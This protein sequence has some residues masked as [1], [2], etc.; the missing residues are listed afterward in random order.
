VAKANDKAVKANKQFRKSTEETSKAV[1]GFF[2]SLKTRAAVGF[3]A[4]NQGLELA[5]KGF[6]F[7]SA[8]I[9]TPIQAFADFEKALIGVQKTTNLTDIETEALGLEI[10][11]LALRI[12]KT[13]EELLSIA[14]SA[15]QLGVT[16]SENILNF[17]ETIARLGVA[18]DV[19]GEEAATALA[20]ILK[21]TNETVGGVDELASVIVKLGNTFEASESEIL[22]V[23][24]EVAAAAT[25]FGTSSASAVALSAALKSL[26]RRAESSGSAVSRSLIEIDKALR[27]GGQSLKDFERITG[28][29]GEELEK[30]FKEDSLVAFKVFV[31]GLARIEE[32]GGS[33]AE[34]LAKLG[35]TSIRT[36]SILGVLAK[37]SESVE[38]AFKSASKEVIENRALIDESN[39]AFSTLTSQIGLARN[40]IAF[41]ARALGTA[42]APAV[43]SIVKSISEFALEVG[44]LIVSLRKLDLEGVERLFRTVTAA[45]L[46]T[47]AVLN[48]SA[49]VIALQKA[50]IGL[51]LALQSVNKA[52]IILTLKIL[53]VAA[54]VSGVIVGIQLLIENFKNFRLIAV[55]AVSRVLQGISKLRSAINRAFG[56]TKAAEKFAK[57]AEL[58]GK[59][60]EKAGKKIKFSFDAVKKPLEIVTQLLGL[61][62][63][64]TKKVTKETEEL[65]KTSKETSDTAQKAS[66]EELEINKRNLEQLR[67]NAEAEKL[68][69]KAIED[70]KKA[71][72]LLEITLKNV[73][74]TELEIITETRDERIAAIEKA[75]TL[76]NIE[77]DKAADLRI[78][79]EQ[80]FSE[81]S[82]RL[83]DNRI[84]N[85]EDE[86]KKIEDVESAFDS[87]LKV[88]GNIGSEIGNFAVDQFT[89]ILDGIVGFFESGVSKAIGDSRIEAE[90]LV[91]AE[92]ES[93]QNLIEARSEA[94]ELQEKIAKL[95]SVEGLLGLDE[96]GQQRLA[97]LKDELGK[98][99]EIIT[100][101]QANQDKL[102]KQRGAALKEEESEIA[103]LIKVGIDEFK[104]LAKEFPKLAKEFIKEFTKALPDIIDAFLEVIP[105]V[106]DA[107]PDIIDALLEALPD[108]IDGLIELLP[109]LGEALGQIVKS[110]FEQLPNIIA[111]LTD[112]LPVLVKVLVDVA[113]EFINTLTKTLPTLIP[114]FIQLALTLINSILGELPRLIKALADSIGPI[115]K[116]L[117]EGI[118][119]LIV[120]LIDSLAKNI[121]P[122]VSALIAAAPDIIQGLV[123]SVPILTLALVKS[124][125]EVTK[126]LTIELIPNLV[127]GIID[128]VKKA[129][130]GFAEDFKKA[131]N[132]DAA[133]AFIKGLVERIGEVG[134]KL[135]DEF[136]KG[137]SGAINLTGG[138]GG[139]ADT[140]TTIAT[141]GLNKIIPGFPG[142]QGGEVPQGFPND[143]F[144]AALTS[145]EN[146]LNANLSNRLENFLSEER[147]GESPQP[148]TIVL[149]VG[150][151]QLAETMLNLN[152]AGFRTGTEG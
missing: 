67:R 9:Q 62:S 69:K 22:A 113:I 72:E 136:K 138:G 103:K 129:L 100:A 119:E 134:T 120:G 107:I 151:E 58:N 37:N 32:E 126:A 123:N 10:E 60:A 46:G 49:I 79:A 132:T 116:A 30:V 66:K 18:S 149:Q 21:V 82:E 88:V 130:G 80:R 99:E 61:A 90:K 131:L 13:T 25:Q 40:S 31:A 27:E 55:K 63:E 150:E 4:L 110:V 53:A 3:T 121:G 48:F 109:L 111:S 92:E 104:N 101:E 95:Q 125:P 98:R 45:I 124:M 71:I 16:G 96:A 142:Q 51:A 8:A 105:A 143:S 70:N 17:A 59:V 84:E 117:S 64:E 36:N 141:G 106:I 28:L 57:I 65:G 34:E 83:S 146:V 108:I 152:R 50:F 11:K 87:V 145:G 86:V 35:L 73:G 127:N 23:T 74:K 2:T 97:D 29:T 39:K 94:L 147:G 77:A 47:I 137:I 5:R 102:S 112:L 93:A 56:D 54:V 135:A 12:P 133:A 33:V 140:F 128:G 19:S 43:T 24:N 78:K 52:S 144:P 42:L 118:G 1:K 148:V 26:G 14:K 85:T 38:K 41:A 75:F 44:K 20:R 68:R 114:Q 91:E 7:V 115:T 76:G 139:A 6:D 89:G 122:I 15:G 81:E